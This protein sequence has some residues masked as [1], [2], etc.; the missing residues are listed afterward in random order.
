MADA[1]LGV[2]EGLLQTCR[3]TI[4]EI[5]YNTR[6]LPIITTAEGNRRFHE[7]VTEALIPSSQHSPWLGAVAEIYSRS[8][9]R[10]DI[11]HMVSLRCGQDLIWWAVETLGHRWRENTERQMAR[12]NCD[13]SDGEDDDTSNSNL[14]GGGQDMGATTNKGQE[15]VRP[16][17]CGGDD[18]HLSKDDDIRALELLPM[19]PWQESVTEFVIPLSGI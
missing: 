15:P 8:A 16:D 5:C 3:H 18:D 4:Q 7:D 9:T 14:M 19:C 12:Q 13:L 6:A 17:Q 11:N 10:E 1:I 2:N